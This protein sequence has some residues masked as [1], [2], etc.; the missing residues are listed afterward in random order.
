MTETETDN[1]PNPET[2]GILDEEIALVKD[3]L[4]GFKDVLANSPKMR[5]VVILEA[6][7]QLMI[8][9]YMASKCPPEAFIP[10]VER[11]KEMYKIFYLHRDQLKGTHE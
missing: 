4:N 9:T 6:V 8:M 5:P 3:L 2:D 11:L 1:S 10:I 7:S